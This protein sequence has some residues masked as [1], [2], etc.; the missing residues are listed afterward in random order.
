MYIEV[1]DWGEVK[2]HFY[3]KSYRKAR[4]RKLG[5]RL[6]KDFQKQYAAKG[7]IHVK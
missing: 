2:W 3:R 1:F 7:V 4:W 5:S 6:L